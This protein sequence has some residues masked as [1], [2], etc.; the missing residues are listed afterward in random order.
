[1]R[2]TFLAAASVALAGVAPT[3]AAEP[4]RLQDALARAR[5]DNPTIR[6]AD[7]DVAAARGRLLQ[8]GLIPA[9][10]VLT[11]GSNRHRIPGDVNPDASV[12]LAQELEVG[13]QRGLRVTAARYDLEHAQ[14]ARADRER[15]VDGEVRRAFAG[16]VAAERRRTIATEA[17]A[18]SARVA[19]VTALRVAQGD[20]SGLD[21]DLARLDA[22]RTREEAA[23]A[24]TEIA[25]A[26]ARLAIALGADPD[27]VFAVED[28]GDAVPPVP[29]EPTLVERALDARPD[30]A[31]ARADRDRLSGQ[32]DLTRRAGLV[33]NPT[34][35]G[36]YSHENGH[37]NLL[38]GEVEV[39][40]PVWN[41]Q[42][43][44][45]IDL[46]GQA[47]TAAAEVARLEREI[48]RTLHVALVRLRV[49]VAA[50][51]GYRGEAIPTV[52]TAR[53]SLDRA[54]AA[55]A[56]S[57]VDVITQNERLRATRRAAVDAWLDLREAE[58]DVVEAIGEEP[59]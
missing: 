39:P 20:A 29:S 10:P 37:E 1:M 36:F 9:N 40:L 49:A 26:I 4:L 31:A 38:G 45:E 35:R 51:A 47:A 16:L 43:G 6:A 12:S 14:Q 52:G 11:G 55:G 7:G 3:L 57:I 33:P 28:P 8:A 15:L 32:A 54:I 21:R 17:A 23:M 46:R 25:R 30:L 44:T 19:D 53:T 24:T 34:I 48:P 56:M 50:W 42:Q 2:C 58:A 22:I 13:G 27:E 18:E 41:R 5:R 59:W